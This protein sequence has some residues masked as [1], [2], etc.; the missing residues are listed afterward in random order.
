MYLKI[1]GIKSALSIN[2]NKTN[3]NKNICLFNQVGRGNILRNE[4]HSFF[5]VVWSKA[6]DYR[7]I[8]LNRNVKQEGGFAPSQ[9][10]VTLLYFTS[11]LCNGL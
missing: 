3:D 4:S 7:I 9:G 2:N 5:L 6:R 8:E 11:C 10:S 1:F